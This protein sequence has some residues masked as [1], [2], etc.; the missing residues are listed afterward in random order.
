MC[1]GPVCGK[2][3][4]DVWGDTGSQSVLGLYCSI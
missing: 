3:V 4:E 2:R 1:M